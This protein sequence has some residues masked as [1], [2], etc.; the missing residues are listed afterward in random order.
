MVGIEYSKEFF[1]KTFQ[2]KTMKEAYLKAVKW[3]STNVI[4]KDE[5]H[6][7]RVEFI[8]CT[9]DGLPTIVIRLYAILSEDELRERYCNLCRES[10]SLFYMNSNYNCDR[11]EA[12]AYQR[13]T[14]DM[15]RVKLEYYKEIIS[16][17]DKE[18]K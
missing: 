12:K 10:H 17:R 5:M 8:K 6:D 11:C 7:V 13:R 16:K 15:L 1:K 3:Y 18:G 2:A 9:Q 14:D 4:S